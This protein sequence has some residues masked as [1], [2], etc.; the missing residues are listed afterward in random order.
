MPDWLRVVLGPI[1]GA[2]VGAV[3]GWLQL[4]YKVVIGPEDRDKIVASA[5]AVAAII[6]AVFKRF[7]DAHLNPTNAAS[8]KVAK[9][10]KQAVDSGVVT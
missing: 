3:A 4:H 1:L 7:V 2:L 10:E 6:G 8:P 5:M 9:A